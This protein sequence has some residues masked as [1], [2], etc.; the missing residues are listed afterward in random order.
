MKKIK[1]VK[2]VNFM[3][4]RNLKNIILL[5]TVLL[6]LNSCAS[7]YPQVV[8][9]PLIKKKED[10][11][12]NAGCFI[13][14]EL[15]NFG[16]SGTYSQG[17]TNLLAVQAY[18]SVDC[19]LRF[20]LQGALGLYKG[21]ENNTVIELYTGY[22]FGTAGWLLYKI[23]A[24]NYQLG[25]AQFNIGKSGIGALNFDYGLGLKGGVIYN[26][27][28]KYNEHHSDYKILNKYGWMAEPSAFIRFGGKNIKFNMIVNYMWM[29]NSPKELYFPMCISMGV[30]FKLGK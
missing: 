17:V 24:D 22:G 13:T 25:F 4:N 27:Y 12:I 29:E 6:L 8:D 18:T 20:H 11:R 21:F 19:M 23:T 30:N 1:T 28:S 14:P 16:V 26:D 2:T 15:K 3:K 10:K 5:Q 7:Y 9:I